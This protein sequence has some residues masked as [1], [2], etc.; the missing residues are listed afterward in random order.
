[1]SG[2]ARNAPTRVEVV[3]G[4]LRDTAG[5]V[6]LAQRMPGKH[7]AGQWEFPGGKREPVESPADALA[8]ELDEELGI[9]VRA[10]EPWLSLTHHYPEV[11]VRLRFYSVVEWRGEPSGREGQPLHWARPAELSNLPMPAADRPVVKALDLDGRYLRIP[12][13]DDRRAWM[14][15]IDEAIDDGIRL[16]GLRSNGLAA[17]ELNDLSAALGQRVRAVGGR[18]LLDGEPDTARGLGADGVELAADRLLEAS[19]RPLPDEALVLAA[20]RDAADLEHAGALGLDFAVLSPVSGSSDVPGQ[21]GFERLCA[22]SP[23]PV[24]ADDAGV[25]PLPEIREL[26]GF[27]VAWNQDGSNP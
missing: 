14:R 20:C 8:R 11:S 15:R 26:G 24:F 27:G 22:D 5:R 9:E 2:P 3:A 18:W 6:L 10:A 12:Q 7:L 16:F 13:P 1:M 25:G 17:E 4:V 23:L 19:E 21:D